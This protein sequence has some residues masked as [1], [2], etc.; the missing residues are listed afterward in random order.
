MAANRTILKIDAFHIAPFEADVPNFPKHLWKLA[1]PRK[2]W[3]P[4][5]SDSP[6]DEVTDD[7]E[8]VGHD[9][10]GGDGDDDQH[11]HE[12]TI[13]YPVQLVQKQRNIYFNLQLS[14]I[15]YFQETKSGSISM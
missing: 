12:M 1:I 8:G 3:V 6:G 5:H 14:L 4:A 11:L 10:E 15:F 2:L 9:E 7:V 13:S